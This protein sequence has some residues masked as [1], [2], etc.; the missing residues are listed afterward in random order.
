[1]P[2]SAEH[3]PKEAEKGAITPPLEESRAIT[4]VKVS[5]PSI[6]RDSRHEA[7]V[8]PF[9]LQWFLFIVSTLTG[10]FLY[11]LDNTVVANIQPVCHG[12]QIWMSFAIDLCR[13]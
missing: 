11:A 10:M 3:P 8:Y 4:G 9:S 5:S 7:D 6:V 12:C 1:M 13:P 2:S